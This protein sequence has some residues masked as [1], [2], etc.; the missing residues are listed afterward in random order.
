MFS[1]QV[2]GVDKRKKSERKNNKKRTVGFLLF[3]KEFIEK[4]FFSLDHTHTDGK[5]SNDF[6]LFI[7]LAWIIGEPE[8]MEEDEG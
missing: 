3:I 8:E 4:R 1:L 2:I 7:S 6:Y 5:I